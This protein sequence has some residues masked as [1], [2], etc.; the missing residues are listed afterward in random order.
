MIPGVTTKYVD[1]LPDMASGSSTWGKADFVGGV[2]S[3][4]YGVSFYDNRKSC[5]ANKGWFMFDDV[6][7][8][9]L[10]THIM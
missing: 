10:Y 4:T 2:S 1:S 8:M 9:W 6:I 7:V 5:R 3:N